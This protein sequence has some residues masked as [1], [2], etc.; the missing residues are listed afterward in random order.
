MKSCICLTLA[1]LLSFAVSANAAILT[2]EV[3]DS[4]DLGGKNGNGDAWN[5][6]GTGP[7]INGVTSSSTTTWPGDA[8]GPVAKTFFAEYTAAGDLQGLKFSYTVTFNAYT[9]DGTGTRAVAQVDRGTGIGVDSSLTGEKD[10][11]IDSAA[12]IAA[13]GGTGY[14]LLQVT[15]GDVS[16]ITNPT[17]GPQVTVTADG[18]V[19]HT[20]RH[21]SQSETVLDAGNVIDASDSS[22]LAS[23]DPLGYRDY[24]TWNDPAITTELVATVNEASLHGY[25]AQ[26]TVVPEPATL[27]LVGFG[28]LAMLRRRRKA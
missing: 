15:L 13:A 23:W 19:G 8:D 10:V 20:I 1:V 6:A 22:V 2:I 17:S 14:E 3:T 9:D 24:L 5:I 7:E 25:V 4:A 16:I 27:A 26:F 28:G 11:Q 21:E 18:F 12:K